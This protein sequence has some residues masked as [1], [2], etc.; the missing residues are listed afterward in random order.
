M[1]RDA[2]YVRLEKAKKNMEERRKKLFDNPVAPKTAVMSTLKK[3]WF[4]ALGFRAPRINEEYQ[5]IMGR[6]GFNTEFFF[7]E[8]VE[9]LSIFTALGA[10]YFTGDPMLT[11][12]SLFT[13]MPL[14]KMLK[15]K[16]ESYEGNAVY[17]KQDRIRLAGVAVITAA[18][19]FTLSMYWPA[20]ELMS[21]DPLFIA[22]A[23]HVITLVGTAL[24]VISLRATH[25]IDAKFF[26]E[27]N[28][29]PPIINNMPYASSFSSVMMPV[30]LSGYFSAPG[31]CTQLALHG[32]TSII[33]GSWMFILG[34][35][36]IKS[37]EDAIL[38]I[39]YGVLPIVTLFALE[40]VSMAY[41]DVLQDYVIA[42][43]ALSVVL[44][45]S[46]AG[47]FAALMLFDVHVTIDH[48]ITSF[49]NTCEGTSG[50]Q[51]L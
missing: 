49:I 12:G 19:F 47:G 31:T 4:L 5:L 23:F 22:S 36:E 14:F 32:V 29:V 34:Q 43:L 2:A 50:Q 21:Y 13:T 33:I 6:L 45:Y 28:A 40:A 25:Y 16:P 20:C 15:Q 24:P 30:L 26:S 1:G 35:N 10:L 27:K 46:V 41:L 9:I 48:A 44:P 8:N 51:P 7:E 37:Q 42:D 17:S 18:A 38:P 3:P 11:L 39:L